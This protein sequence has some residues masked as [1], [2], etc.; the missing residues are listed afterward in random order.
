MPFPFVERAEVKPRPAL[1]VS[2]PL[3]LKQPVLWVLMI[4]TAANKGW[5]G[6]ISLENDHLALGLPVPCVIRTEKIST[7]EVAQARVLG[8]LDKGRL[9]QVRSR[10]AAILGV[11]PKP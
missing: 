11:A 8:R 1:V 3:G 9:A 6:D 2:G 4:T 10:M 5:P 7:V